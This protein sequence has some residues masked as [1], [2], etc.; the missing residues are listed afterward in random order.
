MILEQPEYNKLVIAAFEKKKAEKKLSLLLANSTR[1]KI[2]KACVNRYQERNSEIDDRLIKDFF[3]PAEPGSQVL[4]LIKNLNADKFSALDNYLRKETSSTDDLNIELMAWLI[5]FK[6]R[7]YSEDN[8]L[9]LSD[10][11]L[12]VIDS[13]DDSLKIV[14]NKTGPVI[15]KEPEEKPAEKTEM[16]IQPSIIISSETGTEKQHE[17]EEIPGEEQTQSSN[18]DDINQ[19]EPSGDGPGKR[20]NLQKYTRAVLVSMG[21]IL[22]SGSVYTILSANNK[23][24]C[25]YWSYDH[26]EKTSCDEANGKVTFHMKEKEWKSFRMITQPDTITQGSIGRLYYI[27]DGGPKF[28][29]QNGFYPEDQNRPLRKLSRHIFDKYLGKKADSSKIAIAK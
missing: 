9:E 17:P 15:A 2:K 16:E 10:E 1:A 24:D 14:A 4:R 6:H 5:D 19:P 26:F 7:P 29:T 23:T 25:V 27:K 20:K 3:G 11:E 18:P 22:G 28:Y 8:D 12:A 13:E 21:L